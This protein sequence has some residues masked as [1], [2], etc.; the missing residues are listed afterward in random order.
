MPP[1]ADPEAQAL[2][3]RVYS[4]ETI[5]DLHVTR[6]RKDGALLDVRLA[7]APMHNPDGTVRNVA[8]A[9]EDITDRKAAE[10]QLRKLAH[11]DQLTGLP[12]RTLL[13][14]ELRRLLTKAILLP[15]LLQ[16]TSPLKVA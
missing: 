7:A 15:V 6:R 3:R 8:F 1:Q 14:Q 9:Y 5:R 10:E 13:Q 16:L 12:N 2:F 4:G 11:Y